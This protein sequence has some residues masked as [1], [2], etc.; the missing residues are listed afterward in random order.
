MRL[1]R[2]LEIC[3]SQKMFETLTNFIINGVRSKKIDTEPDLFQMALA[4]LGDLTDTEVRILSKMQA[5]NMYGEAK[6]N[7]GNHAASRQLEKELEAILG[8]EKSVISSLI[9]GL[10]KSGFVIVE[11]GVWADSERTYILTSF[12]KYLIDL[13]FF[14]TRL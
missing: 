9:H 13:I 8:L 4:R 2:A 10:G 5:L 11:Q 12:A 6:N 1:T 3:S 7:S 14:E